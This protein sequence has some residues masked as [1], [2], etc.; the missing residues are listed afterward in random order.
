[1]TVLNTEARL[2]MTN[3]QMP[4]VNLLPP[5]LAEKAM[6]RKVQVGLGVAVAAAVGVVGL[7]TVSAAHG[8][9][10]AQDSLNAADAQGVAL[11]KQVA[12][13]SSVT[14]TYNAAAA[15]QQMLTTAMG[16][17]V[18]YSQVLHDLSL[19]TPSNV[20]LKSLSI[21]Q[22]PPTAAAGGVA[23]DIGTINF[24]G[25]GFSH[26]DLAVWLEAMA[27]QKTFSNVYFSNS[28]EALIGARKVINFTSSVNETPAALSGRYTKPL[29]D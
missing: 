8:V 6:L 29:G 23:T 28:N 7:L 20:W 12:S 21:N 10:D 15:A 24:T 22:T 4:R 2:G 11:Q 17:E 16:T 25:V 5:E 19:S 3:A 14:A 13:Y 1:M 9:H 26:D 18:L 27:G